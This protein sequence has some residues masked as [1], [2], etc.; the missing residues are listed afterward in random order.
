MPFP[1]RGSIYRIK[2]SPVSETG[3]DNCRVV[4]LQ[5]DVGNQYGS[6][7]IVAPLCQRRRGISELDVPVDISHN[8]KIEKGVITLNQIYS[9]DK[10]MLG[11][12]IGALPKDKIEKINIALELSLGLVSI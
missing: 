11:G 2:Q 6:V 5:N 7:V 10:S 3:E 9:I 4:V 1:R 12:K 8:G